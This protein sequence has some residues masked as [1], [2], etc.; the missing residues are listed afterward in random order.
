[1]ERGSGDKTPGPF[2]ALDL[3]GCGVEVVQRPDGEGVLTL[4]SQTAGGERR[5]PAAGRSRG[6]RTV[7]L[8]LRSLVAQPAASLT[9]RCFTGQR[10]NRHRRGAKAEHLA[11]RRLE[12]GRFGTRRCGMVVRVAP[13]LDADSLGRVVGPRS[14]RRQRRLRPDLGP[15]RDV[16]SG[17][18]GRASSGLPKSCS[19]CR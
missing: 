17:W 18:R 6:G 14:G 9:K 7:A 1:M 8:H 2:T 12:M 10:R 19:L 3:V 16:I 15:L 4:S 5:P 13:L 11:R